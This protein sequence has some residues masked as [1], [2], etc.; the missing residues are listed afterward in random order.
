MPKSIKVEYT[1][2]AHEERKRRPIDNELSQRYVNEA[3]NHFSIGLYAKGWEKMA[4]AILA[5]GAKAKISFA[6]KF[7][8]ARE[9]RSD[10]NILNACRKVFGRQ[11]EQKILPDLLKDAMEEKMAAAYYYMARWRMDVSQ[12]PENK[13]DTAI[14]YLESALQLGHLR[15]STILGSI[16]RKQV[17]S[18]ASRAKAIEYLKMEYKNKSG[19]DYWQ[20]YTIYSGN[21]KDHNKAEA[22]KYLERSYELNNLQA[23]LEL[24]LVLLR[25]DLGIRDPDR[26]F[27]I[28]EQNLKTIKEFPDE[29]RGYI[30]K[31][32]GDYYYK[33]KRDNQNALKYFRL[34]AQYPSNEECYF[35]YAELVLFKGCGDDADSKKAIQLMQKLKNTKHEARAG[36]ILGVHYLKVNEIKKGKSLL[37]SSAEANNPGALEY[38]ASYY[39]RNR[40]KPDRLKKAYS[41][42]E[43]AC[44]HSGNAELLMRKGHYHQEGVGVERD[45][46]KALD[47]YIQASLKGHLGGHFAAYTVYLQLGKEKEASVK[48]IVLDRKL[49]EKLHRPVTL[50]A[51]ESDGLTK[52]LFGQ[53]GMLLLAKYF[54]SKGEMEKAVHLYSQLA[55]LKVPY[56]QMRLAEFYWHG[57]NVEKNT[58]EA[59]RLFHDCTYYEPFANVYLGEY[60]ENNPPKVRRGPSSKLHL[61]HYE[62]A[63]KMN[64]PLA[65]QAL[66]R[67]DQFDRI[68]L[69]NFL[70]VLKNGRAEAIDPIFLEKAYNFYAKK[71][72]EIQDEI[73]KFGLTRKDSWALLIQNGPE[74]DLHIPSEEV[75]QEPIVEPPQESFL[76]SEERIGIAHS[77]V[78]DAP[79]IA[80]MQLL[81]AAEMGDPSA[82]YWL[83]WYHE[84]GLGVDVNELKAEE[85]YRKGAELKDPWSLDALGTLL[86]TLD[87]EKPETIF[88]YFKEAA[89]QGN[90]NAIN[91]M[92]ICFATGYGCIQDLRKAL[93]YFEKA[94]EK[95][96]AAAHYNCGYWY[97]SV[98]QNKERAR[99]S[100]ERAAELGSNRAEEALWVKV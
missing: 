45:L 58:Q 69:V 84:M 55:L 50:E 92:G 56:A 75:N 43:R 99:A 70:E 68:P 22:L 100:F 91:N 27:S 44:N 39:E 76:S 59:V 38:L 15:S 64:E 94:A 1:I 73:L 82:Y 26:A 81:K 78:F 90:E 32:L 8:I 11:L 86:K 63:A 83:G 4:L 47:C 95:D 40:L 25:N 30:Y 97:Q 23:K 62:S 14:S 85:Y 17:N 41:H 10:E 20:L 29:A 3:K 93:E 2:Q 96:L 12:E 71:N 16:Y 65:I 33:E 52:D 87:K 74:I 80:L 98:E 31:T 5:G 13:I 67:L 66:I 60:Y 24:P 89:E 7:F 79:D 54:E 53:K 46:N 9:T 19:E 37:K 36:Y 77:T 42:I 35:D 51:L 28:L 48:K 61:E 57:K 6:K 34:G 49:T 21:H 88:N 72:T 18:D